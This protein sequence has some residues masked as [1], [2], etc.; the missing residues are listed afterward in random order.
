MALA[1][2]AA[3]RWVRARWCLR[4][5]DLRLLCGLPL[6][7]PAVFAF[8]GRGVRTVFAKVI[9]PRDRIAVNARVTPNLFLIVSSAA[10]LRSTVSCLVSRF[11]GRG[12]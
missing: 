6:I 9:P 5:R 8:W 3:F 2:A 1:A 11:N 10:I 4:W 7:V 12:Q